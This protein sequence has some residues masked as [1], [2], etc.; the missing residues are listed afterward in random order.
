MGEPQRD[1]LLVQR[2]IILILLLMLAAAAWAVLIWGPVSM[3]VPMASSATG[4]HAALFLVTWVVMTVATMFPATAP[5]FLA[6]HKEQNVKYAPNE[7]F[8]FTWIFVTAYLLVWASAGLATYA[9]EL[10]ANAAHSR[11]GP[12]TAAQLGGAVILLAGV[13]QLTPLKELCLRECRTPIAMT[14]WHGDADTFSKGLLHGFFCVGCYWPLFVT[15]YPLGMSVGAMAI[16]TLIVVAEKALPWPTPVRYATAI[17]PIVYG[18]TVAF[19]G[20]AVELSVLLLATCM[21]LAAALYASAGQAG[22]S[23]YIALMALFGLAPAVMRPTALALNILV[24]SLASFRYFNAGLFRWRTLWPFLLGAVPF[25]FLGGAI[26]L[27]GAYYGPLVGAILLLSGARLLWPRE[28]DSNRDPRDPP[29]WLAALCGVAIGFLSGLTGT[30]GGIF[31][32]PILLFL[33]WSDIR[34]A[35]GVAAAFILCNS[36]AGLLGNVA[37]VKAL[38]PDLWVYAIAVTLGAILGTTLGIQWRPTMILRA[39]G[40]V[41][42]IAG[43]KLIGAY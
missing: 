34:T 35:T 20:G 21:F 2:T 37:V 9:G 13:Y 17:A 19:G 8:A 11:L 33:G 18:A 6:F 28:L 38:P 24:A 39:L 42:I 32:S 12:A 25:A 10:I 29:I 41:L 5:M 3:D 40:L 31:L 16:I 26:H 7:A 4:P 14:T 36:I 43:L 1:L 23:A 22:A 30:G 15:L 27:P